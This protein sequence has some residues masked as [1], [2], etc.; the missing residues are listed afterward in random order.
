MVVPEVGYR[1]PE[2]LEG[3]ESS[4]QE[5]IQIYVSRQIKL[6]GPSLN[7][8]AVRGWFGKRIDVDGIQLVPGGRG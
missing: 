5:D 1:V 4:V 6:H 3:Y 8:R 2:A 7:V